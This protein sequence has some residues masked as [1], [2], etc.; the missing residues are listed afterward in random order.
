MEKMQKNITVLR[1]LMF[2]YDFLCGFTMLI[3]MVPFPDAYQLAYWHLQVNQILTVKTEK[4]MRFH[5]GI[6]NAH[7]TKYFMFGK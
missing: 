1:Y 3:K 7:V 6:C 4:T 5:F 2:K